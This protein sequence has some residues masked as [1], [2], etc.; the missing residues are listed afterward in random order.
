[1]VFVVVVLGV[2]F[3]LACLPVVFEIINPVVNVVDELMTTAPFSAVD[4]ELTRL[5]GDSRGYDIQM[6]APGTYNLSYRRSPAWALVL[7][8]ITF[9]IGVL[10]LLFARETLT[11][12]FSATPTESGTRLLVFG[13]AHRKLATAC[14]TALQL[15]VQRLQLL[16]S[17]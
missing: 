9:P 12:T 5:L 15:R 7:G 6:M 17:D 8:L 2:L 3:V 1:M 11:L 10:L 14:G 16:A 4:S 13:R